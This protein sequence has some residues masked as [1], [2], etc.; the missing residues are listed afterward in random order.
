MVNRGKSLYSY[1][2]LYEHVHELVTRGCP[3]IA[4]SYEAKR[5]SS[6][7][8]PSF[9]LLNHQP[10]SLW[11]ETT[12]EIDKTDANLGFTAGN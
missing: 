9:L 3:A 2:T 8:L 1:V 6:G 10:T 4:P 7:T 5:R 12:D 11:Y